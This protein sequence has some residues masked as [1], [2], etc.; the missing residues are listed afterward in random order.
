MSTEGIE[1]FEGWVIAEM[2]GHRKVAGYIKQATIAGS[3]MMRLDIYVGDATVPTATQFYSAAAFYCITPAAEHL[4][5]Q[6]AQSRVP[7]PVARYELPALPS[8]S[9]GRLYDDRDGEEDDDTA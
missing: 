2:M 4:C 7:Q 9:E 6:Y 5:R 1:N 3:P 8:P